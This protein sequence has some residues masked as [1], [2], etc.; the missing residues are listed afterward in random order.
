MPPTCAGTLTW[1]LFPP[2]LGIGFKYSMLGGGG[3][4]VVG[5][6][7]NYLA[8]DKPTYQIWAS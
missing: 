1:F 6:D 4:D 2:S 7:F 3:D 5:L 8:L